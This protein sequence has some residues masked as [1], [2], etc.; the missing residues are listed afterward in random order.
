MFYQLL[1][2]IV[3]TRLKAACHN[4]KNRFHGK[5]NLLKLQELIFWNHVVSVKF[6]N[7][8]EFGHKKEPLLGSDW[9]DNKRQLDKFNGHYSPQNTSVPFKKRIYY[10]PNV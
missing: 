9:V 4:R 1:C 5:T 3:Q 8:V 7:G 10:S 2:L 6:L